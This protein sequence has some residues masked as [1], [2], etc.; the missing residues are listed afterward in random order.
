MSQLHDRA[1]DD[2]AAMFRRRERDVATVPPFDPQVRE[3]VHRRQRALVLSAS[4]TVVAVIVA[5]TVG[6]GIFESAPRPATRPGPRVITTVQRGDGRVAATMGGLTSLAPQGWTRLDLWSGFPCTCAVHRGP[7]G[8]VGLRDLPAVPRGVP[9]MTLTNYVPSLPE[10][11]DGCPVA[12][13]SG[14]VALWIALDTWALDHGAAADTTLNLSMTPLT[15]GPCG[16]GHYAA[17][18]IGGVPY[19]AYAAFAPDAI[20][21]VRRAVDD[22]WRSLSSSGPGGLYLTRGT[23]DGYVLA[24]GSAGGAPWLLTSSVFGDPL[25][26]LAGA[27]AGPQGFTGATV[28][29]TDLHGGFRTAVGEGQAGQRVIAVAFDPSG[30]TPVFRPADGDPDV[31][32]TLVPIAP[33]LRVD[34]EVGY[35]QTSAAGSIVTP[36]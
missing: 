17:R 30:G 22:T 16:R 27:E 6:T 20:F 2:V 1:P 26:L 24:S 34:F 21:N 9:M 33:E 4:A 13:P 8:H 7:H 15:Q 11:A 28:P 23:V 18:T 3:R 31:A 36:G 35:V 5:V 10:G 32:L 29:A 19:F 14:G 12:P 25:S